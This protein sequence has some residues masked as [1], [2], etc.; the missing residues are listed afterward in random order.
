MKNRN[1]E[2]ITTEI[3]EVPKVPTDSEDD[4]EKLR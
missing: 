3:K 4:L 2:E 1:A